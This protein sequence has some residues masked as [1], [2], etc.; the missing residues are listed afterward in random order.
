MSD[1]DHVRDRIIRAAR[2]ALIAGESVDVGKVAAQVGIDRTTVFR[3][4]GRRDVLI[5]EALW[6]TTAELAW[7]A[8][9]AAH[10]PG[11]PHRAALVLTRYVRMLID[12]AWFRE[13]LH[14]DPTRAMRVLTTGDS[15]IHTKVLGVIS[16]L[17]AEEP[18]APVDLPL[19]ELAY[20]TK[21]VAESFIYADVIAGV[22]PNA[23]AAYPVFVALLG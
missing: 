8:S 16:D 11:T 9:L 5:A 1:V 6:S 21:R 10:P 19:D 2:H 14:R 3:Q 23:D 18:P 12:E 7:P 20:V 22:T 15:P 13:F 4:V 17:L